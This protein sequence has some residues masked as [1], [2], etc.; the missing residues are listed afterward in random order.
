WLNYRP[1]M[2][3]GLSLG[4]GI[5]AMSSYQTDF[6]YL[7]ELR[8]PGRALVDIG[9]EYDFGALDQDYAG[10]K[11][12]IN[13]SNLLD[14]KYV[15]HCGSITSGSRNYGADRTVTASLKYTWYRRPTVLFGDGSAA[16][17]PSSVARPVSALPLPVY[18][19]WQ[20]RRTQRSSCR[21]R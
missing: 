1:E 5:R 12:R 7:P 9:A 2:I 11:L 14:E 20:G 6:T 8:I 10:T 13:V 21:M 17:R 4:A 16:G 18:S 15:S 3:E 19:S